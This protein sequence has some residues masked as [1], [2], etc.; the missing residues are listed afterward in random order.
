MFAAPVPGQPPASNP[1]YQSEAVHLFIERALEILPD[2][3]P[4]DQDA[5]TIA[6]ICSRL[7]GNP[8]AIELAAARLNLLSLKEIAARL[9]NL[10]SLLASGPRSAE[11]R[12]QTL[13]ATIEWSHNLLSEPER[14]LFR[15][16]SVFSGGFSLEA[17][18]V[19]CGREGI[20]Q[21]DV[22]S[23]LGQLAAKSLLQIEPA[24]PE[25]NL[26]TRYR[27][28]GTICSY[29]RIRLDEAGE[30]DRLLGWHSEYFR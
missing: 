21:Q 15:R 19:I 16:L 10:F 13:L 17:A 12:H 20:Q 22:L 23:L 7:D 24:R 4:D 29:A 8:L 5:N 2:F 11:P 9:D 18:E 14:I 28:P 26:T 30:T 1:I 6:E 27:L 25:T 3:N